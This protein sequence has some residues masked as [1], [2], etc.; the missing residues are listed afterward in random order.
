[1]GIKKISKDLHQRPMK[2]QKNLHQSSKIM[3]ET[4]L[5]LFFAK[6]LKVAQKG[7][8]QPCLK[9]PVVLELSKVF[10]NL[11]KFIFLVLIIL[12]CC[13]VE[14]NVCNYPTTVSF[15][16]LTQPQVTN[17]QKKK[18]KKKTSSHC[19]FYSRV[20]SMKLYMFRDYTCLQ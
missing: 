8:W 19:I 10:S 11:S 5:N 7:D 20:Y 14:G 12:I 4:C 15:I 1:M 17:P 13:V 6:F 9:V 18:K 3:V 16:S 2:S